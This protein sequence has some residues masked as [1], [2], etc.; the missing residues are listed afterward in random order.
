MTRRGTDLESSG[1][2][3]LELSADAR[4]RRRARCCCPLI[5]LNLVLLGS[6]EK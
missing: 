6:A 2:D 4:R 3:A 5:P 1:L